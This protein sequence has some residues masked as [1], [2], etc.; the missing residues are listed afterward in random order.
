[1]VVRVVVGKTF[2]SGSGEQ[3]LVRDDKEG[4][5]GKRL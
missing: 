3:P 5:L 4:W 1:M 2:G